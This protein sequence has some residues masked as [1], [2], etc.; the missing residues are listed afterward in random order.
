MTSLFLS[1]SCEFEILQLSL[2]NFQTRETVELELLSYINK[3][4]CLI[5]FFFVLFLF[6]NIGFL[7]IHILFFH[8]KI[9]VLP[10]ST[11]VLLPHSD[12]IR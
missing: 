1:K 2:E 10:H 6:E 12:K 7:L 8:D 9:V 5:L 3:F 11:I 4:V